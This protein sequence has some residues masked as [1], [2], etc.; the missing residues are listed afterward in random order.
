METKPS[1]VLF[2]AKVLYKIVFL[3]GFLLFFFVDK[4]VG[5]A[6]LFIGV[7]FLAWSIYLKKYGPISIKSLSIFFILG[8]AVVLIL[9]FG[10]LIFERKN[11]K[12]VI[13]EALFG[14][15]S[16][17]YGIYLLKKKN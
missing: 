12:Y 3:I 9:G 11:F 1:M 10:V 4:K 8:G 6:I 15:M 16:L 5:M 14:I 13:Y 2:R 17:T 7:L